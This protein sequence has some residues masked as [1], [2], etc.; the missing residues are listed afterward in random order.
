MTQ[1]ENNMRMA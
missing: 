1:F